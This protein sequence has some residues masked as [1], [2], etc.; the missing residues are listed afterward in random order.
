MQDEDNS[1]KATGRSRSQLKDVAARAS[2]AMAVVSRVLSGNSMGH[3]VWG[4]SPARDV[5][6]NSDLAACL[7]SYPR[8]SQAALTDPAKQIFPRSPRS[9]NVRP[10]RHS[11]AGVWPL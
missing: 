3:P 4:A 7:R 6:K 2:V 11:A 1:R 5:R 9:E 10:I 8:S